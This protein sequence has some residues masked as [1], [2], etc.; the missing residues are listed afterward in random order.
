MAQKGFPVETGGSPPPPSDALPPRSDDTPDVVR[1]DGAIDRGNDTANVEEATRQYRRQKEWESGLHGASPPD[2]G[3]EE[4]PTIAR[5]NAGIIERRI[6]S[7]YEPART[8]Y[9]GLKET[10]QALSDQHWLERDEATYAR[11]LFGMTPE[12]QLAARESEELRKRNTRPRNGRT[13]NER[14]SSRPRS[15]SWS[16]NAAFESRSRTTSAYCKTPRLAT[17]SATP[18]MLRGRCGWGVK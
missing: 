18:A 12:Q 11:E 9:T 14:A 1:I 5:Q 13:I 6:Q 17:C 10:T 4:Q 2:L 8:A 3:T 15:L 7:D 16:M